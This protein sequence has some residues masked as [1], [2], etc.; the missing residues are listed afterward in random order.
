MSSNLASVVRDE[1][2]VPPDDGSPDFTETAW[3]GFWTSSAQLAGHVYL[4]FRPNLGV[5]DSYVY[6][7]GPGASAP[8]DAHYWKDQHLPMP[9]SLGDLSMPGGQRHRVEQPMVRY[10]LAARDE[11]SYGGLF[12]FELTVDALGEPVFFGRKHFDQQVRVTG[13]LEVAGQRYEVDCH[14][15]RDRSWYRRGDF[16]LFRSGYAYA[17]SPAGESFLGLFAAPRHGDLSMDDLPLVGGYWQLGGERVEL[18]SGARRVTRESAGHP[19]AV[20]LELTDSSGEEHLVCGEVS[21]VLGLAANTS[22]LS[23][24][25]LVRW[26]LGGSEVIGED[27]DIWSPSIW[28]A[29]RRVPGVSR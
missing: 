29:H 25:S 8:W 16:A 12:G 21:H 9:A 14:A 27:Q 3:Y 20:A 10:H 24:M 5:M 7:W 15:M 19:S 2:H 13:T 11:H 1:L 22:M 26:N 18:V 4:R 23:W 6:V 28:S 17:I